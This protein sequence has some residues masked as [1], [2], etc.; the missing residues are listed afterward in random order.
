MGRP[1]HQRYSGHKHQEGKKVIAIVENNDLMLAPL[2]V[3]PVNKADTVL[4]PDGLNALKRI[5]RLTDLEIDDAYLNLD[6]GFDSRRN[7]KAIFNARA[8]S[9]RQ[10]EPTQSEGPDA[11]AQAVVQCRDPFATAMRGA[12]LGMGR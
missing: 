4:L 9:Q 1:P 2:P 11:Q 6:G 5:A 10:G 12:N 7:R 3:A 8:S